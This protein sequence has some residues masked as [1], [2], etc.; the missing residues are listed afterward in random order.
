MKTVKIYMVKKPLD[1]DEVMDLCQKYAHQAEKVIVSETIYLP[2][3]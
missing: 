3:A 1:I 2:E